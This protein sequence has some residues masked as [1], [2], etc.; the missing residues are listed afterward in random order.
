MY[1]TSAFLGQ[2]DK[3][4]RVTDKTFSPTS[5][6][7]LSLKEDAAEIYDLADDVDLD[8][9]PN[10]NLPSPFTLIKLDTLVCTSGTTELLLQQNGTIV[11]RIR[12]TWPAVV[13][14]IKEIEIEWRATHDEVWQRLIVN[15]SE[16]TTFITDVKDLDWYHVR[17][18]TVNFFDGHS[19]WTYA[20]LHQVI[21][22]SEP[23]GNVTL[24]EYD[25]LEL[26]WP[27]ITEPDLSGY[28]IRYHIGTNLDWGTAVHLHD[29]VLTSSPYFPPVPPYG[30][31]TL[32]IKAI[33]TS[34]NESAGT[35]SCN[36]YSPTPVPSNVFATHDFHPVFAGTQDNCTVVGTYLTADTGD[37]FYGDEAASFYKLDAESFYGPLISERMIYTTDTVTVAAVLMGSAMLLDLDVY[38]EDVIVEFQINGGSWIGWPGSVTATASDYK[39]R[40]TIGSGHIL[41]EIRAMSMIIDAVD[42]D[43]TIPNLVIGATATTIPILKTYY[44]IVA[45]SAT[46]VGNTT[47][48]I[49]GLE[50]DKTNPA[51]P[52][53]LAFDATHTAVTGV[54]ADI[55]VKGY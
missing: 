52:T 1:F 38:G 29:G 14:L 51:A 19:D 20:P 30:F 11:S 47:G 43:E 49:V 35:A 31:V 13:Q 8:S 32:M 16:T 6:I 50:V 42:I 22:K 3:V 12:V 44:E 34:G 27:T 17:A 48:G 21:G 28:L 54:T 41:G 4:Y 9:T 36:F 24:L 40:V 2:T 10:S 46:V 25:G 7:E 18:R 26:R 53:I 39:F 45:V 37:S 15:R 55:I 5:A 23:P 33:D